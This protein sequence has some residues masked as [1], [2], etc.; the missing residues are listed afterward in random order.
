VRRAVAA[1]IAALEGLE[2][3][4]SAFGR[5]GDVDGVHYA[6]KLAWNAGG[7]EEVWFTPWCEKSNGVRTHM[8]GCSP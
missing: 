2:E 7:W 8:Y 5:L 1:H 6:A 3:A 4:L